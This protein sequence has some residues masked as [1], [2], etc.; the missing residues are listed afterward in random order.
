MGEVLELP[1]KYGLI[2]PIQKTPGP[3]IVIGICNFAD[4][5]ERYK[6]VGP[7]HS[8][9]IHLDQDDP[10]FAFLTV[11]DLSDMNA[12]FIRIN[13]RG[14]DFRGPRAV[15]NAYNAPH[16]KENRIRLRRSVD[17]GKDWKILAPHYE[18]DRLIQ[19]WRAFR[20]S[21]DCERKD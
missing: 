9:D 20:A 3:W 8:V 5:D 12:E 11:A 7:I 2:Y 14:T 6:T 10:N 19:L 21:G 16:R 13:Q 1:T 4:F 15:V 18:A 17:A